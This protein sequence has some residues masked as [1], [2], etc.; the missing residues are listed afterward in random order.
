MLGVGQLL[1][2]SRR[3]DSSLAMCFSHYQ[4]RQEAEHSAWSQDLYT[5]PLFRQITGCV[6]LL[7]LCNTLPQTLELN[8]TPTYDSPSVSPA[9]CGG[10]CSVGDQG[11]SWLQSHLELGSSSCHPAVWLRDALCLWYSALVSNTWA[12]PRRRG[13]PRPVPKMSI[14]VHFPGWPWA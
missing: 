5:S 9:G 14:T 4:R 11:V 13:G 6:R 10:S 1:G 2:P 7:P 8:T 12:G 3:G